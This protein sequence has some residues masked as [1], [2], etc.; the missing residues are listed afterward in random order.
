MPGSERAIRRVNWQGYASTF[1]ERYLAPSRSDAVIRAELGR[2]RSGRALDVG[3]GPWGTRYLRAWASEYR[4]LDP[5][6]H[7]VLKTVGWEDLRTEEF[8]AVVA[9]GSVNYL[10]EDEIAALAR[11]VRA[12][13]LLAFNTFVRPSTVERRYSSRTG[14]GTERTRLVPGGPYGMVEHVLEPDDV[15][16]RIVHSFFHYPVR[17]LHGL[18]GSQGLTCDVELRGNTAVFLYRRP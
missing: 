14:Q 7:T 11:C 4:L 1:P 10:V 9:R 15:D 8:D 18:I 12:G 16:W 5:Y 17:A 13:G 3:G 2:R 6:V